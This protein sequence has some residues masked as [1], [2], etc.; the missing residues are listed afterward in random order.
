MRLFPGH[1]TILLTIQNLT[2]KRHNYEIWTDTTIASVK[3]I[4]QSREGAPS[5]MIMLVFDGK[6][7]RDERRAC[8]YNPRGGETIAMLLKAKWTL[9]LDD[10]SLPYEGFSLSDLRSTIRQSSKHIDTYSSAE[11]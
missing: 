9:K 2:G 7:L 3:K 6:Q 4:I 10:T 8:D 5:E 1:R 11:R